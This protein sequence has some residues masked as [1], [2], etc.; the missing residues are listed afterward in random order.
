MELCN[1]NGK[2]QARDVMHAIDSSFHGAL[3]P[4]WKSLKQ[5]GM[6][7]IFCFDDSL[8]LSVQT[9]LQA[10]ELFNVNYFSTFSN[11]TTTKKRYLKRKFCFLSSRIL[12]RDNLITLGSLV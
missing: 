1:Y 6:N 7:L 3:I 5:I 8:K 2:G 11:S 10:N 9:I 4:S 12:T